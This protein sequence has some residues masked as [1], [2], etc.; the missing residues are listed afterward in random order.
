MSDV[1]K[2]PMTYM[3][4]CADFFGRRPG[5]TLMQFRDELKGLTDKDRMEIRE[6]LEQMGYAITTPA[7]AQGASTE[8][9]PA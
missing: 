2:K 5:Q 1:A 9:A 6:G 8:L 4:A 3:N 7:V